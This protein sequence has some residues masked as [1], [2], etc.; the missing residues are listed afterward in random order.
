ML[1]PHQ[2]LSSSLLP[3]NLAQVLPMAQS[4]FPPLNAKFRYHFLVDLSFTVLVTSS[5]EV[6]QNPLPLVDPI[7]NLA[8]LVS[9]GYLWP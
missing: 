9:Q 6:I 4:L 1:Y 3:T 5:D 2:G 8:A 7:S